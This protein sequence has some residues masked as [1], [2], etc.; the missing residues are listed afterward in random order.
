MRVKMIIPSSLGPRDGCLIFLPLRAVDVPVLPSN[1]LLLSF[2]IPWRAIDA[3]VEDR[4]TLEGWKEE[5]LGEGFGEDLRRAL[6][7]RA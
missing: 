6:R 5:L 7:L 4:T 2:A 1:A 3:D